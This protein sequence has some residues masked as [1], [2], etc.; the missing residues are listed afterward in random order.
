MPFLYRHLLPLLPLVGMLL[1]TPPGIAG[2]EDERA[3]LCTFDLQPLLHVDCNE[4]QQRRRIWDQQH[5]L[6]ALQGLVNRDR[7]RLYVLAVGPDA[8]IDR[9]WLK[10]LRAKRQWLAEWS[11]HPQRD[12]L[13]LVARFRP[14]IRGAVV[15]D[16][17]VPA[18]ALVA[19]TAAGVEDL[20]PVRFDLRPESLDHRLVEAADGP[21]LEVKLRLLN[22]RSVQAKGLENTSFASPQIL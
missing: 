21:R 5:L 20:L 13:E 2:S 11:L 9:Y 10:K 4:L 12:L 3:V 19:S 7:P 16:E 8:K 17:R 15:W 22:A 18:T 1:W 14:L 6:A